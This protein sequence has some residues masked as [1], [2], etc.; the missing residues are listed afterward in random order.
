MDLNFWSN[1]CAQKK[2]LMKE[3]HISLSN[4][5]VYIKK[6]N[7]WGPSIF[8]EWCTAFVFRPLQSPLYFVHYIHRS[9]A[10]IFRTLYLWL[11]EVSAV[12]KGHFSMEGFLIRTLNAMKTKHSKDVMNW[13]NA[14]RK[15]I[16]APEFWMLNKARLLLLFSR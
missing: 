2:E 6:I 13:M 12:D 4:G 7:Q 9:A 15:E 3:D 11:Y 1:G 16:T 14:R 8:V 5:R 10:L